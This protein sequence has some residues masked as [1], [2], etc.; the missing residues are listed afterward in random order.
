VIAF[1]D[2]DVAVLGLLVQRST[3]RVAEGDESTALS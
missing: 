2:D 1:A 3:E